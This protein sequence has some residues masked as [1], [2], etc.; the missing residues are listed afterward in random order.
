MRRNHLGAQGQEVR[1]VLA[2]DPPCAHQ[3]EIGF[4][5]PRKDETRDRRVQQT[6]EWPVEGM[7]RNWE[8][9]ARQVAG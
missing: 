6:V 2:A 7:A 1:P 4:V 9:H 8:Y 3:L 5:G